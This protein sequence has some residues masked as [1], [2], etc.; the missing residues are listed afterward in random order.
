MFLSVFCVFVSL[1]VSQ[2]VF[3]DAKGLPITVTAE[4]PENQF[5][6]NVS[7]FDV[8]VKPGDMQI[9]NLIITNSGKEPVDI[10]V[11]PHTAKTSK[12]GGI[13]YSGVDTPLDDSLAISFEDITTEKQ[14]LTLAGE[15]SQTVTFTTNIP[16]KD[17]TGVLLGGFYI[18]QIEEEEKTEE[19]Q[20]GIQIKN[21]FSQVLGVVIQEE[22]KA[23]EESFSLIDVKADVWNNKFGVQTTLANQSPM[24]LSG[25]SLEFTIYDKDQKK[26]MKLDK[27]MFSMAPNS[28]YVISENISEEAL[29]IGDYLL[30]MT[31]HNKEGN[32]KWELEKKFSLGKKEKSEIMKQT[33]ISQHPFTLILI[34]IIVVLVILLIVLISLKRR[35]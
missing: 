15:Q 30:K 6:K 24:I 1:I 22:D 21:K 2:Q 35:Y 3:A 16:E 18:T 26:I 12:N 27:P 9:F 8:L 31:I 20:E 14:R 4:I 17:F 25:Y 29:P 19:V 11:A 28:H 7:Y 33:L 34:G 23:V 10:L 13:D 32:Q 5:N